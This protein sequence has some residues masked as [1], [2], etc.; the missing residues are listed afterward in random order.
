MEPPSA[1]SRGATLEWLSQNWGASLARALEAMTGESPAL[2]W[3]PEPATPASAGGEA[4]LWW[5]QEFDLV[6]EPVLWI[7]LAERTWMLVGGRALRAAGVEEV[8]A[9]EARSTALEIISQAFSAMAQ[10][11]GDRLERAVN[12]A[13][14]REAPGAAPDAALRLASVRFTDTEAAPLLVAF[15]PRLA[16]ALETPSGPSTAVAAAAAAAAPAASERQLQAF[17]T[18]DLLR[19]VELPV[20]VSFGRTRMP[21]EDVLKLT[22]GSVIELDRSISEPVSL[23][24]NDTVVALGE[25]VVI[26]GNYGLRIQQI[27][28][29]E[30]LLRSSGVA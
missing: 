29:R 20:S 12:A 13:G 19:D 5:E 28:S 22:A 11:L 8:Q 18:L 17:K 24:V 21:L 23:I 3:S 27:M 16:G 14:G 15:S 6:P 30:S 2:E 26:E 10:A 1:P 25:V 9:A 7:G 4:L